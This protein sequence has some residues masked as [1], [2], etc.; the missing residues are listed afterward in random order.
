MKEHVYWIS[1]NLFGKE[2]EHLNLEQ[3]RLCW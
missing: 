1:H 2:G 3:H